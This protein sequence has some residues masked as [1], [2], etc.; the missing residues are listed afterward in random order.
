MKVLAGYFI[1][2]NPANT[3]FAGKTFDLF[4]TNGNSTIPSVSRWHFEI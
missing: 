3:N 1:L 4:E 2:E